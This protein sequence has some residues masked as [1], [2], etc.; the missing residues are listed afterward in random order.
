MKKI[1]CI[2]LCLTVLFCAGC[3]DVAQNNSGIGIDSQPEEQTPTTLEHITLAY[4]INPNEH[5]LLCSE[6][7]NQKLNTV[8]FLPAVTFDEKLTVIPGAARDCKTDGNTV[9][10][11]ADTGRKFSDGTPLTAKHIADSLRFAL[12]NESSPYHRRLQNVTDISVAGDTVT[13]TFSSAGIGAVYCLDVPVVLEKSG[14]FYGCGD[15]KI[16]RKDGMNAL[17]K[18]PHAASVPKM[19][20]IYLCDP[21]SDDDL[22]DMFNSGV[23]DVLPT[24]LLEEFSAG[25][26]YES[27]SFLSREMLYVGINTEYGDMKQAAW[28]SAV[29]TLL[30]REDIVKTVLMENGVATA[31]PFYPAW[32]KV[33][34]AK[35]SDDVTGAFTAAGCTV[36]NGIISR[37]NG[38]KI[39]F[40]LLVSENNKTF[41]AIAEK[42]Q[43]RADTFGITV[44]VIPLSEN[45]LSYQLRRGDFELFLGSVTLAETMN[46]SDLIFADGTLNYGK[47]RFEDLEKSYTAFLSGETD[48]A[49]FSKLFTETTP[50]LPIA[51][52]KDTVY[53]TEGIAVDKSVSLSRP[54]GALTAWSAK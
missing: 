7:L 29:G 48:A 6:P 43:A 11:T 37:P 34:S 46:L 45:E 5:P 21:T 25:R 20:C 8:I 42:L 28:R 13:V 2:L 39:T 15:Y 24:E 3:D 33:P 4:H 47:A 54:Y 31:L 52:L 50:F 17:L 27:I 26:D 9:W 41:V 22:A 32:A 44:K 23:L 14:A 36:H 53:Y 12:D 10:L 30:P 35:G 51:F 16:G 18:N 1:I 38:E 40:D 19:D 49:A